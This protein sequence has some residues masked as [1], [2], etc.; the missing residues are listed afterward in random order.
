MQII[1]SRENC[2]LHKWNIKIIR[3]NNIIKWHETT[4][5]QKLKSYNLQYT[6]RKAVQ[7]GIKLIDC[8]DVCTMFE[9][10]LNF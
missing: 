2:V 7:A 6:V 9:Y 5:D 4:V 3:Q 10:F 1:Y 8:I